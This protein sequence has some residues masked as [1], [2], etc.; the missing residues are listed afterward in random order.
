MQFIPQ[1]TVEKYAGRINVHFVK[2]SFSIREDGGMDIFTHTFL[3]EA[4]SVVRAHVSSVGGNA[5]VSYKIDEFI[6]KSNSQKNEGYCIVSISGDVLLV[7][8]QAGSDQRSGY[9]LRDRYGLK[10]SSS[11]SQQ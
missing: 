11:L 5:V 3:A 4:N 8:H 1:A 6:M 2:E 7:T 10:K 9:I